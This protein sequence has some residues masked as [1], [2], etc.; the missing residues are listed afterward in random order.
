MTAMCAAKGKRW[1][2]ARARN[3]TTF[4]IDRPS[5][6]FVDVKLLPKV[7]LQMLLVAE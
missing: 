3:A 6:I 1:R 4:K 2:P 7:E 5:A